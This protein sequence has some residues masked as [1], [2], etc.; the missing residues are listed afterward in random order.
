MCLRPN[1]KSFIFYRTKWKIQIFFVVEY[2]IGKLSI[3]LSGFVENIEAIYVRFHVVCDDNLNCCESYGRYVYDRIRIH[4]RK[5][6]TINII[7]TKRQIVH[8]NNRCEK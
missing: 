3:S 8:S 7:A 4:K 2:I 6:E 1:G 5:I